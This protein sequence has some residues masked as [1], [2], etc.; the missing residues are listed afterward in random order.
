M[1]SRERILAALQRQP[2]DYLPCLPH[3]WSSPEV[4]GYRWDSEVERLEVTTEIL[5]V[6]ALIHFG[7][8]VSQ[9]PS[10]SAKVWEE[11]PCDEKWPLLHKSVSTPRGELQAIVRKTDDWPHGNDIPFYSDFNVSRYVKPWLASLEEVE[12]F[13]Y[14]YQPPSDKTV[15]VAR[16]RWDALQPIVER[17]Q[18]PVMGTYSLGLTGAILLF[19]AEQGVMVSMDQPEAMERYVEIVHRTDVEVLKIMLDLGVDILRRNGWYE[20]TDFWNPTQFQRYVQP[21]MEN[22]IR[23]TH[24]AGRPFNYTMCTGIMPLVPVLSAM[25]LDSLD[26]IE[27]VLGG[28]NMPR[29]AAELGHTKCLW[30]GVSAPIHLGEG[31]PEQVRQAVRQAVE[32]FGKEGFILTAVPSIRPQWPWENVLA[33]LEEWREVR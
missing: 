24:E 6:D 12:K 28:Q 19:G 27:P 20:S 1:T 3:F 23:L 17:Y 10:V 31:R 21:N 18:V 5:G 33:M 8:G 14:V 4:E 29:L 7:I 13:A 15:E 26:T 11:H 22:E 30:G 2:V 25:E 16:E 9:H 32:T